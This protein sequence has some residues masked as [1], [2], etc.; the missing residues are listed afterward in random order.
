MRPTARQVNSANIVELKRSGLLGLMQARRNGGLE[1]GLETQL[2]VSAAIALGCPATAWVAGVAHAHSWLISHFPAQAQDEIYGD[3]PT[4][5]VSAV[6]APRG[7]ADRVASGYRVS[8]FWPFASGIHHSTEW[9]LVGAALFDESGEKIDEGVFAVPTDE[10]EV[11]DDWDVV[12]LSATGSASMR[13]A[14]LIVPS[15]RFLS[16]V[17]VVAGDSPGKHLHDGWLASAAP[18]P[19]LSSC[20][21]GAALGAAHAVLEEFKNLVPPDKIIAYTNDVQLESS[22]THRQYAQATTLVDEA[23]CL[24]RRTARTID[25]GARAGIELDLVTRA[26]CRMDCAQGV[27]RCLEAVQILFLASGGS[28]I[29]K[30]SRL[31]LLMADLQA[32]NMHGI[33]NLETNQ[34]MYG[35]VLLGLPQ[36]TPLI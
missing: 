12:G 1:C 36:N 34:E 14:D 25:D 16:M 22:T 2:E 4:R 9:V 28:G 18:V 27:R 23:A 20:I 17:G 13:A 30:T 7:R 5:L 11:L 33:L 10:V 29:K 6:I 26:R 21:A 19:V 15:H 8:G 35:R 31:G 24:L 32:M 3:D